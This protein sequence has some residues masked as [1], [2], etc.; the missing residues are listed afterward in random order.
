MNAKLT[1]LIGGL[2]IARF[3][4]EYAVAQVTTT[5]PAYEVIDLGTLGGDSSVAYGI[6]DRGQVVGNS[7]TSNGSEH[8]FLYSKNTPQLCCGVTQNRYND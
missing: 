8:A 3:T 7:K 4:S 5:A 1:L 2:T 6:N